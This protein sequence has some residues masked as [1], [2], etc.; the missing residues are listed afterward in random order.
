MQALWSESLIESIDLTP[1]RVHAVA[2]ARFR[3]DG[4]VAFSMV[5]RTLW[6]RETIVA[7]LAETGGALA[8]TAELL[9]MGRT[10]LWRKLKAHGLATPVG[11]ELGED[12][13]G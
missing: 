5:P 1:W 2:D 8:R 11:A 4:G 10:T 9:G 13:P 6:E 7:A 3:A 12:D